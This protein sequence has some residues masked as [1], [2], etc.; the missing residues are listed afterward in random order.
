MEDDRNSFIKMLK[1]PGAFI[2]MTMSLLALITVGIGV[3][4]SINETGH[5]VRA[6]DEGAAAHI[7]QLLMTLQFPIVVIFGVRWMRQA[8][9][10]TWGVLALQVGAWLT[11]CAPVFLLGL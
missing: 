2:P 3:A 5:L 9:R 4:T 6:T 7:F 11:A 10:Q 8:P 1:R